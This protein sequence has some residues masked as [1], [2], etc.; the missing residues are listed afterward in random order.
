MNVADLGIEMDETTFSET[1][2]SGK[3]I[4]RGVDNV[5]RLTYYKYQFDNLYH[6][7]SVCS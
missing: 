7:K 4:A 5:T 1:N 6:F 3:I 2:Q